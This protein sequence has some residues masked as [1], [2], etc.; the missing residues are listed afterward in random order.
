MLV[1]TAGRRPRGRERLGGGDDRLSPRLRFLEQIGSVRD[2]GFRTPVYDE[3][4]FETT[5]PGVYMAGTVCGGYQTGRW[6]IENGRFHAR[7]IAR[8]IAR[9]RA[10]RIKFESVHWKTA[11]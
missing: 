11:E 3:A 9:V 8:H 1:Q 5:R 2:D 7:Q 4:T 6:F 10:E